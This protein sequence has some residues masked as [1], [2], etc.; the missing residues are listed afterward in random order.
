MQILIHPRAPASVPPRHRWYTSPFSS[1]HFKG[2]MSFLKVSSYSLGSES[3]A[4]LLWHFSAGLICTTQEK[5]TQQ[6]FTSLYSVWKEPSRTESTG[7]RLLVG[8]MCEAN[9]V[10]KEVYLPWLLDVLLA[11]TFT[12]NNTSSRN[13]SPNWGMQVG[14]YWV[15]DR[16]NHL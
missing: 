4:T 13:E 14:G 15:R 11:K 16:R 9:V 6:L 12:G 3:T 1:L 10:S 7:P 5:M 8:P 2:T